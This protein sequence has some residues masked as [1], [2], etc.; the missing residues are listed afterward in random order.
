LGVLLVIAGYASGRG[1]HREI[2]GPLLARVLHASLDLTDVA[3]ILIESR[4]I[5][6]WQL[7]LQC[8]GFADH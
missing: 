6:G 7:A 5:G 8:C 3:Q 1:R 2:V 4:A